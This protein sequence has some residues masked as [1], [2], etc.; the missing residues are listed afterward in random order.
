MRTFAFIAVFIGSASAGLAQSSAELCAKSKM[1]S[2]D[3][4]ANR[5]ALLDCISSLAKSAIPIGAVMA[6]NG[7]CPTK[8]GWEPF[9]DG[10][11]K[12]ILGA[13]EG[14]LVPSGPHNP[15]GDLDPRGLTKIGLGDQGGS[16]EHSLTQDEMPGH[17]HSIQ[18]LGNRDG[19][20]TN[21]R[22]DSLSLIENGYSRGVIASIDL[23]FTYFTGGTEEGTTPHNNM[24]PFIALNLCEKKR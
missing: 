15:S 23:G 3:S 13:G 16:E 7:E 21:I 19:N 17:R 12:F 4:K 18:G 9:T 5:T 14:I 10:Q 2:D 24:P 8:E 11:G 20:G 6:F 22:A 1:L